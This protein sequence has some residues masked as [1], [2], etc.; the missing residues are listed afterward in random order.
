MPSNN[1]PLPDLAATRALAARIAPTLRKGDCVALSGELG[2]GKTEFARAL[3]QALGVTGDI[4]SPTFTLVQGY[5]A[6]GLSIF[7]FDLYRL[8]SPDEL[9]ELGWD[10]ALADGLVVV[11]WPER[12]GNRLP[13]QRLEL[14]FIMTPAH[15]RAVIIEQKKQI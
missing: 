7:H 3:L 8:K 1:I 14:R 9:D 12:A 13:A 10:D 6:G 4:P 15:A 11:E 5:D 2:A